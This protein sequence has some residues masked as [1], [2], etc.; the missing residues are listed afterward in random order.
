MENS[1]AEGD[2]GGAS[3]R[4]PIAFPAEPWVLEASQFATK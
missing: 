4:D 2:F 3:A 1:N